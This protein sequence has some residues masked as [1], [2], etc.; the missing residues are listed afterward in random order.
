MKSK[1]NT[2]KKYLPTLPLL[3]LMLTSTISM[4]QKPADWQLEKMP[5][6]LETDFAL[7]SLPPQL[8]PG[9][10]VYL[11]D[12][13]K[14]YYVARKGTNGFVCYVSRTGWEWGEFRKDIA[15]A[16]S[17]DAEGARTIFRVDQDVEAMRASGKFT[18]L[19][20]RDLVLDRIRKG[21]Y[22]APARAGV[23]YMLG[24]VMRTYTGTPASKEVM[25]MN[26]PHYMFYAPYITNT[27]IG[28]I[29]DG[30]A[31][32]PVVINPDDLLLGTRKGPFGFII[33]PAG[34]KEA[35]KIIASHTDLLKRLIAYKPYFKAE[36]GMH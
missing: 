18:A 29:P 9:A 14:G 3:F 22:K 31:D 30:K 19:Q 26:M 25:T 11:L 8:R 17:F 32:G 7:S 4:A 10:T 1:I 36:D 34:E 5:A 28:N 2:A 20:I 16:I 6:A 12:P 23:S 27:D 21:I 13:N 35:A 24:P 15:A 33:L